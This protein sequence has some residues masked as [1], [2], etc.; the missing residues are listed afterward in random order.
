MQKQ[1]I[2]DINIAY[3][4]REVGTPLVLIH[5]FPLDHTTWDGMISHLEGQADVILPDLR[6]LGQSDITRPG[7]P[8]GA[9]TVAD[10]AADIAGLLDALQI[11]K[12]VIVG[13]SMGGY[14]ALAFARAYPQRLAG[15]GLVST[16]VL[17]DNDERKAGRYAT[18]EQV[19]AQ[20]VGV[21]ADGMA[22]KLSA[23]PDLVPAIRE[24]ILRQPAAGV[25]G[26]LKAMAERPDSTELLAALKVPVAIVV[27][28]ADA[29]IPADRSRE[30]KAILPQAVLI[31]L[32]GVGHS[33]M[34]EA[35]LETAQALKKV[36]L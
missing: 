16:Q 19:A 30:M 10:M 2:N 4:R 17:A 1:M 18:A 22:P 15:L 12:A 36:L 35:P 9:Y 20:G 14:V 31:E 11:E 6:G 28:Q 33:P 23:N 29:L 13:H 21:V 7:A 5:G 26:A 8:Q 32:P 25:I 34:L 27:G 24:L 3:E